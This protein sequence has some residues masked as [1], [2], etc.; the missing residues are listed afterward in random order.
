MQSLFAAAEEVVSRFFSERIDDPGHCTIDVHGGRYV[1]LR[2]AA[3]SFE[4]FDLVR[5][6]YGTDR[7][8]K[9]D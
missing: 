4:F 3:L 5:S 9:A 7:R 1:L 8:A 2:T 6:L